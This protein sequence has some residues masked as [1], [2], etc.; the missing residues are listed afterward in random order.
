MNHLLIHE[1]AIEYSK[2]YHLW[3]AKLIEVLQEIDHHKVFRTM[4]YSSLHVYATGALKLSDAQA[5]AL[6]AIA[7]KS[8]VVPELKAAV[9]EGT[10]SISKAVR[11]ISVIEPSN[12]E[13]WLEKAAQLTQ[14]ELEKEVVKENPVLSVTERIRPIYSNR[15]ELRCGI[16]E[17]LD[18]KLSRIKD[19]LSQKLRRPATLEDALAAM[20]GFYLQK[21][22]PMERARRAQSNPQRNGQKDAIKHSACAKNIGHRRPLP[23]GVRHKTALRDDGQCIYEDENRVR[24][25]QRR[26]LA[27]HHM[28]P[29]SKGGSDNEQNLETLCFHHHRLRHEGL[30]GEGIRAW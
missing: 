3:Q 23:S 16:N 27:L 9:V 10:I 22:D 1:K 12:K 13:V 11:I 17:D 26:W 28:R 4:G 6:I 2:N 14:R 20:A 21:C 8:V 24:C 30:R 18:K 5:Y 19:I 7:R 29:V 15:L 25:G